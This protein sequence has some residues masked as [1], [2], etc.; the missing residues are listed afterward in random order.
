MSLHLVE[1]PLPT[2]NRWAGPRARG[3]FDEGLALHHLLAEVFGAA[4]LQPFRLLVAP[5]A[6]TGTLYAYAARPAEAL[7]PARRQH[8][9]LADG[10]VRE[11]VVALEDDA[12][13]QVQGAQLG[14]GDVVVQVVIA[15]GDLAAVD[16]FQPVDA[17][18]RRAFPRSAAA[19]DGDRAAR[20]DVEAGPVGAPAFSTRASCARAPLAARFAKD[21]K[22]RSL[23]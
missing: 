4:A 14:P 20:S 3:A 8:D 12:H 11:Q 16:L 19:D 17:A 18:Q 5:R 10:Q 1:M 23:P 13:V 9:V 21:Q 2:L 22:L 7:H 6:Q 15:D